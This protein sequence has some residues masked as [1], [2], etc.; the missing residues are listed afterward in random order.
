[1]EEEYDM[2][3]KQRHEETTL[4]DDLVSKTKETFYGFDL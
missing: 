1:M 3:K 4:E 2:L